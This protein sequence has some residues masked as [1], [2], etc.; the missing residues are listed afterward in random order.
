MPVQDAACSLVCIHL[1]GGVLL[2]PR[3]RRGWGIRCASAPACHLLGGPWF[4]RRRRRVLRHHHTL[5]LP[6]MQP[7]RLVFLSSG[8]ARCRAKQHARK[9]LPGSCVCRAGVCYQSLQF[10]PEQFN[11]FRAGN[12]HDA[13]LHLKN[14]NEQRRWSDVF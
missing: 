1:S 2:L 5:C 11:S 3:A 8:T 4:R 7:K 14:G 9:A 6:Q 12:A 10:P 13:Y